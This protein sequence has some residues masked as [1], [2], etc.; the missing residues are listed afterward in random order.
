MSK[1]ARTKDGIAIKGKHF[2]FETC[3]KI[4]V[5]AA[6]VRLLAS[7]CGVTCDASRA[8]RPNPSLPPLTC[9]SHCTLQQLNEDDLIPLCANLGRFKRLKTINLVSR[10][11]CERGGGGRA[12]LWMNE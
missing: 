2:D 10:G 9:S 1:E 11:M 6:K 3:E 4:D 5:S 7:W 8:C 12:A